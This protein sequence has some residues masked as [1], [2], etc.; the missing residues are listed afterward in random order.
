METNDGISE[1]EKFKFSYFSCRGRI[2]CRR[3]WMYYMLPI[4]AAIFVFMMFI[5]LLMPAIFGPSGET[6]AEKFAASMTIFTLIFLPVFFVGFW[7]QVIA[8]VKRLHDINMSGWFA[9][10]VLCSGNLAFI[11][12]GCIPTNE[13]PSRFGPL[14]PY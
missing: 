9:L 11:F 3:Y 4:F 6:S 14:D 8:L 5:P 2:N 10:L 7:I 12:L 13:K 1:S